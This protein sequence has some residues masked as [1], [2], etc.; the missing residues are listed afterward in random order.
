M[1]IFRDKFRGI[2][3]IAICISVIFLAACSQTS[4]QTITT[5]LGELVTVDLNFDNLTS[6]LSTQAIPFENGTAVITRFEVQVFD[7]NDILVKFNS[8]NTIDATGSVDT[9]TI[10]LNGSLS[11]ALS[12]GTYTFKSKAFA[13]NKAGG[14]EAVSYTHLTLPTKA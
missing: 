1:T 11:V 6:G 4:K 9:L 12:T 13:P 7:Q 2:I 14:P 10:P 8:E 5:N 3:A